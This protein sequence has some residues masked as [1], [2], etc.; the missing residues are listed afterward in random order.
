MESLY[1]NTSAPSKKGTVK[2]DLYSSNMR[3]LL[4][5]RPETS[6]VPAPEVTQVSDPGILNLAH[7]N[8]LNVSTIAREASKGSQGIAENEVVVSLH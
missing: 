6:L 5:T 8:D 3:T 7:N 4:T 2:N 1:E